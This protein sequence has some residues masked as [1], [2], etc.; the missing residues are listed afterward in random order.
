ME[1]A[2]TLYIEIEGDDDD[3]IYDTL[4]KLEH[5]IKERVTL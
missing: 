2:F 3:D 4:A 5:E 1:K